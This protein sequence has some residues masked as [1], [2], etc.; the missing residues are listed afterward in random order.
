MVDDV[1]L[2]KCDTIERCLKRVEL[3]YGDRKDA[4]ETD[5][6]VQ[7]VLVLNLQRACQAAIDLA[8]GITGVRWDGR[9]QGGRKD[10]AR[11]DPAE[12][13]RAR[14]EQRHRERLASDNGPERS[15]VEPLRRPDPKT[16]GRLRLEGEAPVEG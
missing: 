15:A 2:N 10:R 9:D 7:D 6:D 5:F 8:R 1:L 3:V 16:E 12:R 11:D 13:R 14:G 4:L